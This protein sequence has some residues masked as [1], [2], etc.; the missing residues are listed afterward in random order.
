MNSVYI[1]IPTTEIT[2]A[3]V[4]RSVNKKIENIRSND[5]GTKLL[6]EVEEPVPSIYDNYAWKTHEDILVILQDAE[7]QS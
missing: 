2:I 4:N 1:V 7:W 6:L 3:M 5:L